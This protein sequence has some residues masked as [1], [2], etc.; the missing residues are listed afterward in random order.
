MSAPWE[1]QGRHAYLTR[2]PFEHTAFADVNHPSFMYQAG[3]LECADWN[4]LPR[5]CQSRRGIVP[6]K[7]LEAPCD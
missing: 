1:P 7:N 4:S 5:A 2:R 3:I 6:Q